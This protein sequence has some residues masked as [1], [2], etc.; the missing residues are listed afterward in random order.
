MPVRSIY[1]FGLSGCSHIA[2]MSDR[3]HIT[4]EKREL[5]SRSILG[6]TQQ[7]AGSSRL[8][9]SFFSPIHQKANLV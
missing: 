4:P 9:A 7:L 5:K 6:S 8:V 2:D 1:I 3:G